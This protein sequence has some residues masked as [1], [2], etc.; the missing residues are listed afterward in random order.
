MSIRPTVEVLLSLV[1]N[2]SAP[3]RSTAQGVQGI[4]TSLNNT[5]KGLAAAAV[6]YVT[7]DFF[8]SS[9]EE[10]IKA[11]DAVSELKGSV[12]NAGESFTRWEPKI[13]NVI[14]GLV[15]LS[16]FTDD[17]L[18][19]A[20]S[21]LIDNTGKV[22]GSLNNMQ[23]VADIAAKRHIDLGSAADIVSK[24][25]NGNNKAL[26][27]FGIFVP[28]GTEAVKQLTQ[29]FAGAASEAA[30]TFG[31]RV[32][33]LSNQWGEFKEDVG[34][35]I[36][37][38][39]AAG[40]SVNQLGILLQ[41]VGPVVVGVIRSIANILA[42]TV[43]GWQEIGASLAFVFG[44][45]VEGMKSLVGRVVY[46]IG[47][48]IEET[49]G[50]IPGIGT[51]LSAIGEKMQA[52]GK[53]M[54][55]DAHQNLDNLKTGY[56]ETIDDIVGLN[57]QGETK[58][59]E[60]TRKGAIDRG[61]IVDKEAEKIAAALERAQKEYSDLAAQAAKDF[62]AILPAA[63][64]K[65]QEQI[66]KVQDQ[67]AAWKGK[68]EQLIP[69]AQAILDKYR[70]QV[71]VAEELLANAGD[72]ADAETDPNRA[73][74]LNYLNTLYARAKDALAAA[75]GH[76]ENTKIAEGQLRD[77]SEARKRIAAEIFS[78]K[79]DELQIITEQW[80]LEDDA[81]DR[82]EQRH[83][84]Q[85]AANFQAARDI[86]AIANQYGII[87][88][89]TA[90]VLQNTINLA[91]SLSNI[92]DTIAKGVGSLSTG[93]IVGAI[94]SLAGILGGLFGNSPEEMARRALLQKN[95][96]RLAELK[97]SIGDLIAAQSPGA[98]IGQF[99]QFS[100]GERGFLAGG[101]D[102]QTAGK[103]R[104]GNFRTLLGK[105]GLSIGD[106]EQLAKDM[107]IDLGIKDGQISGDAIAQ[108]FDALDATEFGQFGQD[109]KTQESVS[110][111]TRQA[112]GTDTVTQ[113]IRDIIRNLGGK[114]KSGAETGSSFL[115]SLFDS[116]DLKTPEGIAAARGKIASLLGDLNS[117]GFDPAKFGGLNGSEFVDAINTF[118]GYL[119]DLGTP[120]TGTSST[121]AGTGI[122]VGVTGGA[123]TA[124]AFVVSPDMA[125]APA[126][127]SF[128]FRELGDFL[129]A[130]IDTTNDELK[131]F[132][133]DFLMVAKMQSASPGVQG[134]DEAL[135][136]S[137]IM[138]TINRGG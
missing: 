43:Q 11:A 65:I 109:F 61:K 100:E 134:V 57:D 115:A 135:E 31:G 56:H 63:V 5:I 36:I 51:A 4:A 8:K 22:G 120:S 97:S 13:D 70:Q 42:V 34:R 116:F 19:M 2:M 102:S 131:R 71:P 90:S 33:Q 82:A 123:S 117:G 111:S 16:T 48:V 113:R 112:T 46:F 95:S 107:G 132:H 77:I 69:G 27:E 126:T 12:V 127:I 103:M 6:T 72:L 106:A 26:K 68:Q 55:T 53:Q 94:G 87:D 79:M 96:D 129:G 125:T 14:D 54:V 44:S 25:M 18:R 64:A 49:I 118:I 23:L 76:V 32:Q 81:A 121:P 110:A 52:S 119:G 29:L 9:I 124:P 21:R 99:K 89:R 101:G 47:L 73:A 104:M 10:A 15:K 3:L 66:R 58:K 86:G 88:D 41:A 93:D 105:K 75:Q 85:V 74:A 67:I 130:K 133:D 62:G 128:G 138:S 80:K 122:D 7:A 91:Q 30:S 37:S 39:D 114:D 38:T 84:D 35:A 1:D 60:A 137:R 45:G 83:K 20:L 40:N 92:T 136:A 108:F 17:D 50:R 24:A 28:N 59:T 78:A 98:K